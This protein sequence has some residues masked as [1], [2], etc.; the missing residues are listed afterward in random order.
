MHPPLGTW[1]ATQECA[2]TGNWTGDPLVCSPA[3]SPLNHTSQ[4]WG[5]PLNPFKPVLSLPLLVLILISSNNVLRSHRRLHFLIYLLNLWRWHWL[6]K[7]CT[8]QVYNSIIHDLYIV[9]CA[10]Q[11]M[12]SYVTIDTPFTVF[13]LLPPPFPSVTTVLLSVSVRLFSLIPLP[14]SLCS[15]ATLLS[16]N[17]QSVLSMSLLVYFVH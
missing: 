2:L 15:P 13:Y 5:Q 3:L 17:R 8:F 16:D 4:G 14:F 9:L 11:P 7:L 1:P 12:S 6:T 10:Y